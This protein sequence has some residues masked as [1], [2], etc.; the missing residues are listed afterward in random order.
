MKYSFPDNYGEECIIIA[1][2]KALVPLVSGALKPFEQAYTWITDDDY[3]QGYNAFAQI[4]AGM[5]NQCIE[6]LIESNRQIYRLLDTALNG[7]SYTAGPDPEKPGKILVSPA[8]PDAPGNTSPALLPDYGIRPRFERLVNIVDNLS[9][10]TTY[11][12]GP[13]WLSNG[14][15]NDPAGLRP[16][17]RRLVA[18]VESNTLLPDDNLLVA[19]RGTIEA[20]ANDNALTYLNDIRTDVQAILD[21]M[22]TAENL[23]DIKDLLGQLLV[24]LA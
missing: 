14:A 19:L 22:Q 24:L 23:D 3:E 6:L 1:L 2:D 7:A 12:A 17:M 9:T 8:I 4:Q 11:P 5:A 10:G 18:G 15:L 21:A 16:T 20:G 13:E